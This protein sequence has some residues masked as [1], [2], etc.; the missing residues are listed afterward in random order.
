MPATIDQ[1]FQQVTDG[2]KDIEHRL[3]QLECKMDAVVESRRTLA[4]KAWDV[5]R[6]LIAGA[7]G[8]I[9]GQF[10]TNPPKVGQ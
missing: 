6:M 4:G 10:A 5:A 9:I 3:T 2:F 7:I 8:A 1:L